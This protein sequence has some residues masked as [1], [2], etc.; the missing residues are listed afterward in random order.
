MR[1][2]IIEDEARIAK[3]L[4]RMVKEFFLNTLKEIICVHSLNEGIDYI[5]NNQL[6]LLLLDLNLN[7]EN[8]FDI[9]QHTVSEAFHTVVVSANKHQALTAFEY[10]VLDFVPKPFNK[11]RLAQAFN[12]IIKKEDVTNENLQFLAVKKRGTIELIKIEDVLYIKGAGVYTEVY[13]S[14]GQKELHDKSLE[15]LTQLLPQTF[16]R[17]HKSYLIKMSKIK[18]VIIQSGSKYSVEL[19][20]GEILPVGRTR[21]KELKALFN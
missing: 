5:Q 10:G 20:N 4:E 15:K 12:R 19:N 1:I 7:G 2:L 16:L 13:L 6:D 11:E 17:I 14:N 9:L 3:R 21:Y 18:E 8:G